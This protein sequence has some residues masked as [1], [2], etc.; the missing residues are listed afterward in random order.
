MNKEQYKTYLRQILHEAKGGIPGIPGNSQDFGKLFG[1]GGYLDPNSPIAPKESSYEDRLSSGNVARSRP[2]PS[3]GG[4]VDPDLL[5][6]QNDPYKG[7]PETGHYAAYYSSHEV[8]FLNP[9]TG[10]QDLEPTSVRVSSHRE[11]GDL[12]ITIH[13]TDSSVGNYHKEKSPLHT[14]ILPDGE[15][16]LNLKTMAGPTTPHVGHLPHRDPRLSISDATRIIH[17]HMASEIQHPSLLN[18]MTVASAHDVNL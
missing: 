15:S 3:G 7:D 1:T 2:A 14:Y 9:K 11:Y 13:K 5:R 18:T 12:N 16:K 8:H 4:F 10:E 6:F 17:D